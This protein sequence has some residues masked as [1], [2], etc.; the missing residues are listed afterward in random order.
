[1]SDKPATKPTIET[2]TLKQLCTELKIPPREAR[3]RLCLAVR[4]T[5]KNPELARSHKP[6]QAWEWPKGSPALKEVRTA[7]TTSTVCP[8]DLRGLLPVW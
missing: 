4:D 1:M 8:R 3:E 5:K 6:G 2:I 7:L